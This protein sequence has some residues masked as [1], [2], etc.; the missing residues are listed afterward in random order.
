[1]GH[2]PG[3]RARA[4]HLVFLVASR[5]TPHH[6][7][8]T[9]RRVAFATACRGFFIALVAGFGAG[10]AGERSV[11]AVSRRSRARPPAPLRGWARR[12]VFR[13]IDEI[14]HGKRLSLQAGTDQG[15]QG[16]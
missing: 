7:T 1:M 10:L 6:R 12:G 3:L 8:R 11:P 16:K 9:R 4:G 13:G 15:A 2:F 14:D 5:L